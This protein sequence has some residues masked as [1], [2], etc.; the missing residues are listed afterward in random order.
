M[1]EQ[2]RA[3]LRDNVLRRTG[4]G[5][6]TGGG[7]AAAALLAEHKWTAGT[8]TNRV[9]QIKRWWAFCDEDGRV[10]LPAEEGD[11]LAYIGFLTLEGKVA[12]RS[13]K[14]Y[15]SAVSQYHI[16][17]GF[18]SPTLGPMVT[19]LLDAYGKREDR[20][21][22]PER[23]RTGCDAALMRT[24][25]A[26]GLLATAPEDVGCCAM[27]IFAYV[28]QCRAVTVRHMT[29]D[30]CLV[31][32]LEISAVL[33]HRKGKAFR[34][35]L[36]LRYTANPDWSRD[37]SP[38]CLLQRWLA[39][40]PHGSRLFNSSLS[41]AMSRALTLVGASPPAG[42]YYGSHS[43]RIG[44][45]NA[46]TLLQFGPTWI[47]HRL[48]WASDAMFSTYFDSRILLTPDSEWFFAHLRSATAAQ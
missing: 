45:F 20:V 28:F 37:T 3:G 34:R 36:R 23:T 9:S 43:P 12:S 15:V 41:H 5:T 1:I 26:H 21:A 8:W 6:A 47:M 2:W 25:L 22:A 35:P 30:D 13:A 16:D 44:G 24:V 7:E 40:R 48:D 31:T 10:A 19:A 4:R 11:V 38:H 17:H 29:T 18:P 32:P 46:L 33:T 14:Q 39:V 27:V 42:F